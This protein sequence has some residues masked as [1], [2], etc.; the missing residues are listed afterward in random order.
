M[1]FD[2]CG[3]SKVGFGEL[4]TYPSL[5]I[6]LRAFWRNPYHFSIDWDFLGLIHESQQDENLL[7]QLISLV[8]GNKEAAVANKGHVCRVQYRTI[9]NR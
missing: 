7:T 3:G 8:R 1:L 6:T 5:P 9:F 4:H 2:F